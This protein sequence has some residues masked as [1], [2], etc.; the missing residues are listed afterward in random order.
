MTRVLVGALYL[1]FGLVLGAGIGSLL[2]LVA[3]GLI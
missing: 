2:W 3:R 1:A